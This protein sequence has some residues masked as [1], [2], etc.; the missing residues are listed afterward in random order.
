MTARS[1]SSTASSRD[2]YLSQFPDF[3]HPYIDDIVD[4]GGDGN[5]DFQAIAALLGWGEKLWPL[6][7]MQL[8]TQF[9]NTLNC[10]LICSMT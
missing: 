8:D 10:F 6:I 9:V 2:I 5:Y 4:M 1:Q 7:Q 3:L